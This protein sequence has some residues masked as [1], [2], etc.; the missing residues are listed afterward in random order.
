MKVEGT[1][2]GN[3]LTNCKFF[4]VG[5]NLSDVSPRLEVRLLPEPHLRSASST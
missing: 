1:G 3:S 5:M 2:D 4:H